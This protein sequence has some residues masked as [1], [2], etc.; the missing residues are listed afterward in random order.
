[1]DAQGS[2]GNSGNV[3]TSVSKPGAGGSSP[4]SRATLGD[5]GVSSHVKT[6]AAPA[7]I[8]CL[9]I[10]PVILYEAAWARNREVPRREFF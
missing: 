6:F 7:V 5:A 4:S 2:W 8:F 3:A 10:G 1:M 9:A